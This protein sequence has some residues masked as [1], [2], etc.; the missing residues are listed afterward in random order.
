MAVQAPNSPP[1]KSRRAS[2][3]GADVIKDAQARQRRHRRTGAAA[4]L[5]AGAVG[6]FAAT[7]GGGADHTHRSGRT[8]RSPLSRSVVIHLAR[9]R[10]TKRFVIQAPAGHAYR[11]SLSAPAHTRIRL[12]MRINH[13]SGWS[14]ALPQDPSCTTTPPSAQCTLNFASGGNPGGTWA[15]T[16][17]KTTGSSETVLVRV[18]FVAH[19]GDSH[20]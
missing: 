14:L 18:A 13:L 7:G 4:L 11:V 15:G 20:A 6:A 10:S 1:S 12:T 2:V 3:P 5:I 16:L 8:G 17:N 9:G 19:R